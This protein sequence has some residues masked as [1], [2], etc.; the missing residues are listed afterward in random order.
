MRVVSILALLLLSSIAP[1]TASASSWVYYDIREPK[2]QFVLED[3]PPRSA[4]MDV[5]RSAQFCG[6]EEPYICFR[7]GEF[8]FALPRGFKG[9]EMEWTYGGVSYKVS[10]TSRRHILGRQYFT[11]NIERQLGPHALRFHFTR[12][13]GVIAITTVGIAQGMFLILSG[14]CGYAAPSICYRSD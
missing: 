9:K 5:A 3:S 6:R 12:E 14:K 7:A 8:E 1:M 4:W 2:N 11:Y 10:G 13:A